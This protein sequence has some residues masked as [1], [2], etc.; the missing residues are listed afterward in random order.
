MARPREFDPEVAVDAAVDVFWAAGY[1]A[2]S[3]ADLCH[4]T[5][6]A[7]SSLYNTFTSKRELYRLALCR[8]AER[9]KADQS[10]LLESG[11]P[12]REVIRGFLLAAVDR[13]LADPQRRGCLAVDAAVEIGPADAGLA[14]LALADFDDLVET[15][16]T[17]VERG[18]RSGEFS[19]DR[20][21]L[22]AA[23]LVHATLTGIH[24]LGRVS[25]DRG[26]LAGLADAVVDG[27]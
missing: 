14:E 3:T 10:V 1:A 16:R 17:L 11:G 22:V 18:Q 21:P 23:R 24:V 7:R 25:D 2:T 12:V 20:D 27:L 19:A 5:G 6:V 13:Q 8:Y 26:R 15:F 4:G 9:S